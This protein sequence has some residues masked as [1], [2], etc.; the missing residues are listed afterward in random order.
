[1]LRRLH[2]LI[3]LLGV[4]F[5]LI[6]GQLMRHHAPPVPSLPPD[7]RMMYISRHIYLLAAALL[8]LVLGLYLTLRPTGWRRALQQFGS[9]LFLL[10]P[11]LSSLAFFA[12]PA[13][14]LAGRSWRS[15][16]A[17][18]GLFG[19]ALAHLLG[20]YPQRA[21]R[22]SGQANGQIKNS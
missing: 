16:F 8:N 22:T 19:G 15:Y 2:L 14:G 21:E 1:M 4:L 9:L 11:I 10:S 5:F 6:T 12:E 17:L 13:L 7:L 20:A 18:L 3:G